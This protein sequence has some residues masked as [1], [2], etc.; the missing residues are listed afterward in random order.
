MFFM[1]YQEPYNK[2]KQDKGKQLYIFYYLFIFFIFYFLPVLGW[3]LPPSFSP[4]K[5]S[6][7][8]KLTTVI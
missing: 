4:P 6:V 7:N 8:S 1:V 3:T 5:D 2:D